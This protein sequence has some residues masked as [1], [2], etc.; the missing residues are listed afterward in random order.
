[1]TLLVVC[2]DGVEQLHLEPITFQHPG[3]GVVVHRLPSILALATHLGHNPTPEDLVR[4]APADNADSLMP[5]QIVRFRLH[6]AGTGLPA[7][8]IEVRLEGRSPDGTRWVANDRWS[9]A[10]DP[11]V[12]SSTAW[13]QPADATWGA[14]ITGDPQ[15]ETEPSYADVRLVHP[16][17]GPR[18]ALDQS[19]GNWDPEEDA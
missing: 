16:D 3:S 18:P 17:D 6:L 2:P 9:P 19:A 8:H 15:W 10:T 14:D 4:R 12:V 11:L 7:E 5:S 1:M 13:T